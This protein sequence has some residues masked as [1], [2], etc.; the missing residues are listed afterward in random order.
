MRRSDHIK[1]IFRI[2]QP[3][4]V[5]IIRP[6]N[7]KYNHIITVCEW[8]T[9]SA[10]SETVRTMT[11]LVIKSLFQSMKSIFQL[12]KET[13]AGHIK[14]KTKQKTPP[15]QNKTKDSDTAKIHSC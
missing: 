15:K 4:Y 6:K 5:Y 2:R 12:I 1:F 13:L 3:E 11:L 14:K 8:D 7:A 9:Y 10:D